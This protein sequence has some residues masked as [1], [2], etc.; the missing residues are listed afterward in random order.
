[1]SFWR[2]SFLVLAIGLVLALPVARATTHPD[3][4]QAQTGLEGAIVTACG[5][6]ALICIAAAGAALTWYVYSG[7]DGS[8]LVDLVDIF[9]GWFNGGGTGVDQITTQ[10]GLHPAWVQMTPQM[11]AEWQALMAATVPGFEQYV[12]WEGTGETLWSATVGAPGE[13]EQV[14]LDS[15]MFTW[16]L[17]GTCAGT[18]IAFKWPHSNTW[19]K[20]GRARY[21]WNGG[22]NVLSLDIWSMYNAGGPGWEE[23]SRLWYGFS[24]CPM[25][26]ELGYVRIELPTDVSGLEGVEAGVNE[27]V[28]TVGT[29]MI[30]VELPDVEIELYVSAFGLE[31]FDLTEENS[32]TINIPLNLD[33]LETWDGTATLPLADG[34][35]GEVVVP[36][37]G[38]GT[39]SLSEADKAWW[40]TWLSG[41]TGLLGD[42]IDAVVNVFVDLV[43]EFPTA[44][45]DSILSAIQAISTEIATVLTDVFVP[46]ESVTARV[47]ATSALAVG[48]APFAW[49][50]E[51]FTGVPLLFA[52][53]G[54]TCPEITIPMPAD[55]GGDVDLE[56]CPPAGGAAVL[57]VIS[58]V[59]VLGILVVWA[60]WLYR[61]LVGAES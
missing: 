54:A 57:L 26:G 33:D 48:L 46:T 9:V 2:R 31:S 3:P 49:P 42:I 23:N 43:I 39:S 17:T 29:D 27:L 6:G 51:I 56:F 44:I 55:F 45:F 15:T 47:S 40:E 12:N 52:G 16:P 36:L 18:Y 20:S 41:I 5:P 1:M 28:I 34:T 8:E 7:G 30:E 37:T 10:L 19:L 32:E 50:G 60:Y 25:A 14:F 38:A 4:V 22:A 35:D 61:R 59:V 13:P 11:L 21:Y 24:G 58:R 53:S